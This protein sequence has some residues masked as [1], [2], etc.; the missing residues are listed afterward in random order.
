MLKEKGD[1]FFFLASLTFGCGAK[2]RLWGL[3]EGVGQVKGK[4]IKVFV[5]SSD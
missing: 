2:A 1:F 3:S 5:E 4:I